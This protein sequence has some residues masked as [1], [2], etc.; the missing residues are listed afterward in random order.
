MSAMEGGGALLTAA[1]TAADL[2]E[3]DTV[4]LRPKRQID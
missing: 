1:P 2:S 4:R 3:D